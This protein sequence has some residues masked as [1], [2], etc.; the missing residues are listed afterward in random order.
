VT[1]RINLPER[2]STPNTAEGTD[3][4]FGHNSE[5]EAASQ[6]P[7]ADPFPDPAAPDP[8]DPAALRISSDFNATVGLK[9]AV[10]SIP[11]R[12][13][14]KSWWVRAHPGEDYRVQTAVIELRGERSGETYLVAPQLRAHL[15]AEPTFR[16]KLLVAAVTT[17]GTPFLW[18]AALPR[19]D[20]EDN[21]SKTG[22]EAVR[23]ATEGWVRVAANMAAGGYDCW[24]AT[25]DLPD[26]QW[27]DLSFREWLRLA[28]KDR[29]IDTLDHSV[30]RRLRGEV[31]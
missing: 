10:L 13:P 7:A 19:N 17:Q 15:A 20:R 24:Q 4:P 3:F 21:W 18:E 11:A 5:P 16:P 29:Y 1:K 25:G 26:P 8:F 6:A 23:L 14:D 28:F 9:K 2:N 12:K 30:L 22:L 27:P 31:S